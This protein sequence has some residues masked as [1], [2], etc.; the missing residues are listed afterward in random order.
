MVVLPLRCEF[1]S[2]RSVGCNSVS[3]SQGA[4][5]SDG[6]PDNL[7]DGSI[8]CANDNNESVDDFAMR[9]N[10]IV[11][12]I[13][14]LGESIEEITM[15]KKFLRIVPISFIQI[16]TSIEQFGDLKNM[17]AEEFSGHL[18]AHEERLKG[19]GDHGEPSLFLTHVEWSS[20]SNRTDEK[21][22]SNSSKGIGRTSGRG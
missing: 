8:R 3:R 6:T 15:V 21:D 1:M 11:I 18:K 14:S 2:T 20:R 13:R 9:L 22:S 5:R 12:G 16:V 10:T 19:Y 17:T 7:P 4:T